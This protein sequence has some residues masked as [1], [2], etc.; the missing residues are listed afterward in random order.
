MERFIRKKEDGMRLNIN[1]LKWC[2][3]SM[4]Q[5]LVWID[6]ATVV[7]YGPRLSHQKGDMH[8]I[9]LIYEFQIAHRAITLLACI[10]KVMK[11]CLCIFV[12]V[13][14]FYT[15]ADFYDFCTRL[16]NAKINY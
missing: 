16:I 7:L 10:S 4:S 2:N 6:T 8:C 15:L 12:K 5:V 1:I 13:L 11:V 14:G 9:P 3:L